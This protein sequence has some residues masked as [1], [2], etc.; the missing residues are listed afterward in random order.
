MVRV[1][2]YRAEL[3]ADRLPSL[4][5]ESGKNY[6][7]P[8][9]IDSQEKAV[10]VFNEVLNLSNRAEEVLS[11]LALDN[12]RKIIGVFLV[13]QG[14]LG[15]SL[16]H[17]REIYKRALLCG[18]SSII[19]AHNHPSGETKPSAQDMKAT[20]AAKEAGELM[21]VPLDDHLVIGL[22]S[23]SSLVH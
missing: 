5:K 4:V 1:N 18:A 13:S 10:M 23:Y 20:Q 12:S 16:V 3:N 8:R 6:E 15:W 17:P 19:L 7:I 2:T 11:M 9:V 14:T 22:G 21:G